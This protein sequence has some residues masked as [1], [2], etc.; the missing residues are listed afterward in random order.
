MADKIMFYGT[1][2]RKNAIARVRLVD[3][4]EILLST[5]EVWMNISELK[6]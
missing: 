5:E 4:K 1:G 6:L 3:V 2:R